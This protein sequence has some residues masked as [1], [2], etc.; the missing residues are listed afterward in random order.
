[1]TTSPAPIY[2]LHCFTTTQEHE[3]QRPHS[4]VSNIPSEQKAGRMAVYAILGV[5]ESH[6]PDRRFILVECLDQTGRLIFILGGKRG[7]KGDASD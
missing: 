6:S 5:P 2:T 1:M 7:D 4:I 3:A